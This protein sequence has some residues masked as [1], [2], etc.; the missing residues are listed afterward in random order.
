M[1]VQKLVANQA[2]LVA[3]RKKVFDLVRVESK[4]NVPTALGA[5]FFVTITI[6]MAGGAKRKDFL[7]AVALN[8]DAIDEWKS[9]RP[10][11]VG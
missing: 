5:L 3:L 7:E 4:E 1:A 8:W 9:K 10:S 6:A 11:F 2:E